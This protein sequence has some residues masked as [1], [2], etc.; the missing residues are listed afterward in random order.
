[1]AKVHIICGFS[2]VGKSTL[3]NACKGRD[4]IQATDSDSSKYPKDD[5][6]QNYVNDLQ[7][8]YVEARQSKYKTVVILCSTHEDVRKSLKER[9]LPFVVVYPERDTKQ[10]YLKRYREH[11]ASHELVRLISDNWDKWLEQLGKEERTQKFTLFS[12]QYLSDI[13]PMI[14]ISLHSS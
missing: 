14:G 10:E 9:G 8:M 4:D 3:Y 5:F 13:A 2:G 1:M 6:P 11:G 12:G 7:R